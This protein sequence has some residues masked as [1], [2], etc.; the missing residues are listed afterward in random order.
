MEVTYPILAIDYGDKHFGLAISDTK[1]ILA[2]PLDTISISQHRDIQNVIK[3]ILDVIEEQKVKTILVGMPQ[4]FRENHKKTTDKIKSFITLLKKET[5]TPI[6]TYDESFST[7]RAQNM[8]ISSG[9]T[10]KKSRGKINSIAATIFLQEF[11]NSN[12]R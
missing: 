4:E 9:Q 12:K 2:Q 3:D 10:T 7:T 5:E 11:L 1:G 6:I 8:L